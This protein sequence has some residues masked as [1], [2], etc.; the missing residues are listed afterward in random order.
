MRRHLDQYFT[1]KFATHVLLQHQKIAGN[2]IEPCS[3]RG[4]I[5]DP[6]RAVGN[7]STNDIDEA[8][9]ADRHWDAADALFWRSIP[10]PDW[11]V[12]NPPFSCC[13]PIIVGAFS[14][15]TQGV[16]MLLR[17]SYLEPCNN[18][19]EFL[20]AFPP[21]LIVLPRIS[22]TGDGKTDN[23]TCAWFIW[24]F[25][26]HQETSVKVVSKQDVAKLMTRPDVSKSD[27]SDPATIQVGL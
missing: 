11:V 23:V 15:A 9:T 16:A 18:R 26:R 6:L 10:T 19:A 14:R 3:G 13:H 2:I 12:S 17:L 25:S 1:P 27:T 8:L 4:D 24:D 5:A 7:V 20:S 22:F 21:S